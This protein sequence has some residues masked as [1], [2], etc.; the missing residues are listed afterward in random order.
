MVSPLLIFRRIT[1]RFARE[2]FSTSWQQAPAGSRDFSLPW[3]VVLCLVPSV[4]PQ[5][6]RGRGA[7]VNEEWK[8]AKSSDQRHRPPWHRTEVMGRDQEARKLREAKRAPAT[9]RETAT[10]RTALGAR[11]RTCG[12][13]LL[14]RQ[15]EDKG[16]HL[17][18]AHESRPGP[19]SEGRRTGLGLRR[20][21][22][23][24]CPW[25]W[26]QGTGQKSWPGARGTDRHMGVRGC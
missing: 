22:F 18:Q 4:G 14:V 9:R 13:M 26:G 10:G 16:Q 1:T 20:S 25:A 15:K 2:N 5:R 12:W 24:S 19:G 3:G 17:A 21:R 8:L 23:R 11:P 7:R 6:K